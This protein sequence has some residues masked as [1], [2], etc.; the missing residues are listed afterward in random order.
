MC[1]LLTVSR[2]KYNEAI[3]NRIV[4]DAKSNQDGFGL[5]LINEQGAEHVLRTL[6][7]DLVLGVLNAVKWTRMFLHSRFATQGAPVLANTHGWDEGSVFYMHNGCIYTSEAKKYAVDSQV[8]GQ[9][10]RDGGV[11][12]AL[13][14]LL[15]ERFANVFL[16]DTQK[17]M[18][19]VHRSESG[20]LYTDGEGNYSTHDVGLINHKVDTGFEFH[21]M[22]IK[23]PPPR[24]YPGWTGAG[25]GHGW[26]YYD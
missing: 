10:V 22:P 13:E 19:I 23:R 6:D 12:L 24:V 17:S 8:I 7:V 9:W 5:L 4:A 20:S 11:D 3:Q 21:E 18:Y 25:M 2:D 26:E 16:I 15:D 14:R 1:T